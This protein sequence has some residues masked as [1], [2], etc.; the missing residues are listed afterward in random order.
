MNGTSSAHALWVPVIPVLIDG[1]APDF[2]ALLVSTG[3]V[4]GAPF[5]SAARV[6]QET[7]QR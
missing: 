5:G 4:G 1:T 7:V 3:T 2:E 6:V